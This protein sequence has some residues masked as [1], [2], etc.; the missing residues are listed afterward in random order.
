MKASNK[1]RKGR[2]VRVEWLDAVASAPGWIKEQDVL[3]SGGGVVH[4]LTAGKVVHLDRETLVL[5]QSAGKSDD[6]VSNLF[7]IP[8]GWIVAVKALA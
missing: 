1:L 4:C 3:E 6:E 8:R 2:W 5:A 7:S